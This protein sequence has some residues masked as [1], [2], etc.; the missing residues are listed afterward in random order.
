MSGNKGS[1]GH[2]AAKPKARVLE[3]DTMLTGFLSVNKYTIEVDKQG[4]GTMTIERLLMERDNAVAVLA[5]D[6]RRDEV[7]LVNEFRAGLMV[8]GEKP[9]CNALPGGLIDKG[10]NVLQAAAREILEETGQEPKDL[11]VILSGA[12]VSSGVSTESLALVLGIIDTSKAARATHFDAD[13]DMKSV[14][15]KA[16]KFIKLASNG[17]LKNMGT[18][19]AAFWLAN[20]KKELKNEL[21]KQH[22]LKARKGHKHKANLKKSNKKPHLGKNH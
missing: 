15:M 13:E 5:Y 4:G 10:E 14:V 21:K 8:G 18:C 22:E 20:H 7:L 2:P 1:E 11:S 16:D 9:F 17:A 3:R 19:M 6:P 12:Y